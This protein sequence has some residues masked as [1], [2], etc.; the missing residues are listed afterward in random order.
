ML[1]YLLIL[2]KINSIS[3]HGSSP[4]ARRSRPRSP[5]RRRSS[6]PGSRTAGRC[7]T[8]TPPGCSGCP[9]PRRRRRR[10]RPRCRRVRKRPRTAT[11]GRAWA[12]ACSTQEKC[13]L[14]R[15]QSLAHQQ[16]SGTDRASENKFA[17]MSS[18]NFLSA[19]SLCPKVLL[20]LNATE[21]SF[22]RS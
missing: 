2:T 12:T 10:H 7:G 5:A 20:N 14:I 16:I 6:G 21:E 22:A 11:Q 4:A 19:S 15:G 9:A 18:P 8:A 17:T 1:Q 13:S 3:T